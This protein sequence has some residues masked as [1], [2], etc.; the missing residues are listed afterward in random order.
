MDIPKSRRGA[1]RGRGVAAAGRGHGRRRR[2]EAKAAADK[3]RYAA[4]LKA[5][6]I[7]SKKEQK[8]AKPKRPLSAYDRRAEILLVGPDFA[9]SFERT[10]CACRRRENQRNRSSSL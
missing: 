6:G 5:A 9:M 4:A 2:Y 7:L 8:A 10:A 3:E 1:K